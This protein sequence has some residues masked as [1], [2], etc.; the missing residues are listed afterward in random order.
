MGDRLIIAIYFFQT[1]PHSQ[2]VA[3]IAVSKV[4]PG[5]DR[6]LFILVQ[7]FLRPA[8]KGFPVYR[9]L[10]GLF[11][12]GVQ[13]FIRNRKSL[14]FQYS[15]GIRFYVFPFCQFLLVRFRFGFFRNMGRKIKG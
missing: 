4:I 1:V 10:S 11:Q 6:F 12:N 13:H 8:G 15:G 9:F 14:F 5:E 3:Q 2:A 7:S